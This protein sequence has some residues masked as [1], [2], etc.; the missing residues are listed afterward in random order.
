MWISFIENLFKGNFGSSSAFYFLIFDNRISV[1]KND[2]NKIRDYSIKSEKVL[3]APGRATTD[4][5]VI[6]MAMKLFNF[7]DWHD[8]II[9]SGKKNFEKIGKSFVIKKNSL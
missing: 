8:W 1:I 3:K 7:N 5:K 6:L 4:T 9:K 2:G